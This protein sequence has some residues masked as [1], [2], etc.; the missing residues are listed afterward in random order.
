MIKK[1][2]TK[3]KLKQKLELLLNFGCFLVIQRSKYL[4]LLFPLQINL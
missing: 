4:L 1:R 2:K 3:T